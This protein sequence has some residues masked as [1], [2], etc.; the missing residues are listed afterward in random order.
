MIDRSSPLR[1]QVGLADR[2]D[3]LARRHVALER[4]VE[5]LA[6]E[7]DHRVVVADRGDQ[8]TLGVGR[9]AG[10]DH[11][12]AGRVDEPGF[13]VLAVERAGAHAAVAGRT[14]H[15][16]H[17]AAPAVVGRGGELHDAVEGRG[18]EVGK[19]HLDHRAQPHQRHARAAMPMKPSSASGV[20]ITRRGPNSA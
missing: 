12:E 19:L 20:F 7:V 5:R 10:R 8:Q 4:P 6:L 9:R 11:L 15:R 3:I 2:H 14:D 17:G 18:D 13:G 16:G 1:G